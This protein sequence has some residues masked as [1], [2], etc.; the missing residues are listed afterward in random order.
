MKLLFLYGPPA[1]GKLTVAQ[2]VAALT[3][4]PLFHNHVSYDLARAFFDRGSPGFFKVVNTVREVVFEAAAAEPL[5]GLIFTFV[6][7]SP[8]D[9]PWV[10]SVIERVER[11]GGEVLFVR[12][13]CPA[14]ILEERVL[15]PDRSRFH[16]VADL[17]TLRQILA[18]HEVSAPVP[19]RESLSIDTSCTE[20]RDAARQIVAHYALPLAEPGE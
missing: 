15:L 13:Y 10:E 4:W 5:D 7:G 12:L 8:G 17:E 11:H 2:E 14:E 1:A 16:K 9:D 3:G 20:P 18:A 19:F 6:Y